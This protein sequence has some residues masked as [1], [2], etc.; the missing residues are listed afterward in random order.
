MISVNVTVHLLLYRFCKC[1]VK[2]HLTVV[3][4]CRMLVVSVVYT[5]CFMISV[6]WKGQ[7]EAYSEFHID[8]I[9]V[10]CKFM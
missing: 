10:S 9:H 2:M 6:S 3:G 8:F 5:T 7:P 4:G 1:F